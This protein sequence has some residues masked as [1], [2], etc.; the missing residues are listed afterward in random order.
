MSTKPSPVEAAANVASPE[1]NE[2][3]LSCWSFDRRSF[4]TR[5]GCSAAVAATVGMPGFEGAAAAASLSGLQSDPG[6]AN[7]RRAAFAMRRDMATV[8]KDRPRAKH[9][10]NGD[11][12]RYG[13]GDAYFANYSKGLPKD[14]LGLPLPGSYETL[15]AA[16]SSGGP[17]DFEAISLGLGRKLENPQAGLAFDLEGADSHHLHEPPPPAFASAEQAGEMVELYWMALARDVN[18]DTY[19]SEPVIERAATDLSL[20][21]DFHGPRIDGKVTSA[22]IFRGATSGDVTGPFMSQFLLKDVLFGAN[23]ISGKIRTTLPGDDHMTDYLDWLDVQAG[24]TSH[25]PNIFDPTPRYI[26]NLRDLAQ[27]V[28]VD[29]LYQAYLHA[30]LILL[31][32]NT[33]LGPGLPLNH[34]RTQT[35]FVEFGAPHIMSLVTEV[36]TRALKAQWFQKWWVHRRLRP[37]EFAGRVYH[38]KAGAADYPIHDDLFNSTVLDEIVDK[39][40]THLLPMAFPEGSPMH[41]AYGSGHATV[42]GACVTILKAFFD[43]SATIDDPKVPN[44]D[45]TELVDYTDQVPL[46][47]LGELNKVASNVAT[48]RNA[49]G[50]HWRT[51]FTGA[52]TLGEEVAISILDEQKTCHNQSFTWQ[53]TRFDGTP[54]T[55]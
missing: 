50:V 33:P 39:H 31:A 12:R 35:G 18:F 48:G 43:E 4:L 26:R 37:E 8:A 42:A 2:Q 20:L 23:T 53:F 30:C 25:P 49:A 28:H 17:E 40:G 32:Q 29:A 10:T 44:Q 6:A 47:V 22:T 38:Q 36:A 21:S 52:I 16:I 46:T 13:E 7:R 24:R 19:D 14:T 15:R 34:S 27:W 51:D 55:I 3:S 41:P 54:T 1:G 9:P 45:G 11:E 5:V